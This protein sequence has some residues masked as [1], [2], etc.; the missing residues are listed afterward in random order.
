MES[1]SLFPAERLRLKINR[2]KSAVDRPWKRKF[3]GY[4]M[5][6]EGEPRLKVSP[7]SEAKLRMALKELFRRGRGR[8]IRKVV[9]EM[10]RLLVGWMSYF[11]LAQVRIVFERLDEWIRR[12]LRC[13]LWRQWKRVWTR[14]KRLME[15]GLS[16]E[17]AW[18]SATNGHGAWWNVGAAHMHLAFPKAYF[19]RLGLVS[20]LDRHL[21]LVR[22]T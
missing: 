1:V 14:A 15:R 13:I 2:D 5:T 6:S 9:E 10:Q 11:R 12:R 20:L 4:S 19:D 22:C 7:E 17:Q 21:G 18:I 8:N 16:E 3:L